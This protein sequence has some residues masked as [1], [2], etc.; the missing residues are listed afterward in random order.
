MKDIEEFIHNLKSQR[1]TA[2]LSNPYIDSELAKNLELYLETMLRMRGKK[3]LLI[4]EAP[5][6]KGCKVTGIPFTSGDVFKTINHPLINKIKSK[7]N[8]E[9]IEKE[10][11]ASMVWRYLEDKKVT[12]LF[13]NSFPFHPHPKKNKNKNRAPNRQEI[14][15]GVIYLKA[16]YDLYKPKKIAGIGQAGVKCAEL[17][18][19]E[20]EIKYIRHP[21]FGGKA[22]FIKGMDLILD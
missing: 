3:I 18:F 22:D 7:I 5:G 11:T 12:P 13:W 19:P 21:S 1:N 17:A 20:M 2:T 9:Y 8:L 10:N 14:D 16:L 6:Y 15:K 4:G